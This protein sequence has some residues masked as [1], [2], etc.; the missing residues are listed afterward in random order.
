M[1]FSNL[2]ISLTVTLDGLIY[3][4][5]TSTSSTVSLSKILSVSYVLALMFV[6]LSIA[7]LSRCTYLMESPSY[8]VSNPFSKLTIVEFDCMG[9]FSTLLR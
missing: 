7:S 1:S 4:C 9:R 6:S 5:K 8:I 2:L 3:L